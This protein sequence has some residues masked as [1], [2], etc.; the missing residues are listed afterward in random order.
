VALH[1]RAARSGAEIVTINGD[2]F[3]DETK[4]DVL[5]ALG[6]YDEPPSALIYSVAA[7][8]RTDPTTKVTFRS[9]LKP[10]GEAFTTK[11]VKLDTG[12]V[13]TVTLEPATREEVDA[14]VRVMGGHDWRR[15]VEALEASSLIDGG[16]RTVAFDYV[17]PVTTHPIYRSGAIGRAKA[18]LEATADE[19]NETLAPSGGG[20]WTSVNAAAVTQ[21]SAAIPAVPL[22]LSLLLR[23]AA[24]TGVLET[25]TDQMVR[26][27]DDFLSVAEFDLDA[28]RRIRLDAWELND[29]IQQEIERRWDLVTTETLSDLAAFEVFRATFRRLFGF[30]VS[31][32]DYEEPVQVDVPWP[33]S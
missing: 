7:P 22:Y 10:I 26:L 11:T 27:F 19:L 18:H 16:F 31:G 20:A 12:E 4:E 21:S 13:T 1:D 6:R 29:P 3:S 17:G 9:V 30:D 28:Q 14:T 5:R 25:P 15:W 33:A 32:V 8:A 2:C 23:V 24:D